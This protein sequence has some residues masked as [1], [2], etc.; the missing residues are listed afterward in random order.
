MR[1][2]QVISTKY[3]FKGKILGLRIDT[4]LVQGK[5]QTSREI[6]SH[7]DAVVVVPIDTDNNVI[8]VR[9][10]RHAV[11]QIL[12]EAPAGII[13]EGETPED[14]AIRELQEEIGFLP[15]QLRPLFGFWPSPGFCTEFI[16]SYIAKDLVPSKL[17]ADVDENIE[18]HKIPLHRVQNLIRA[19][20]I[21]DSKTIAALLMVTCL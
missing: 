7:N 16:Y 4:V 5:I 18:V 6:I 8:L 17:E 19:G 21:Q 9:Q 11:Q 12:L 3:I 13:E 14:C 1:S 10:Y 2:E 15:G 20:E